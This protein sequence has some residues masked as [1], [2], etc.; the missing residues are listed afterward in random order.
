MFTKCT[1][2]LLK[3]CSYTMH[4][5]PCMVLQS[6]RVAGNRESNNRVLTSTPLSITKFQH[7]SL[8]LLPSGKN[9]RGWL[10]QGSLASTLFS[11]GYS[12]YYF[13][14]EDIQ[15]PA[16]N[17]DT[18]PEH[19]LGNTQHH[20]FLHTTPWLVVL[21]AVL[22]KFAPKDQQYSYFGSAGSSLLEGGLVRS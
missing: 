8:P 9:E 19:V 4:F 22:T 11:F 13:T 20:L 18:Q 10:L 16:D 6:E 1:T 7:P 3:L 17:M 5:I 15:A 21:Q 14:F 2:K 12:F